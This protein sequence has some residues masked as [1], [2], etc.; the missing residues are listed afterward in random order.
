MA[1]SSTKNHWI[2]DNPLPQHRFGFVHIDELNTDHPVEIMDRATKKQCKKGYSLI[3]SLMNGDIITIKNE[4]IKDITL[5]YPEKEIAAFK[6]MLKES[7][8]NM[9]K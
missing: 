9:N 5:T 2:E 3:M 7:H 4:L 8:N 6:K 1:Y